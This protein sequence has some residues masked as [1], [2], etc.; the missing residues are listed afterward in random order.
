M[1]FGE[2]LLLHTKESRV[3][4][5]NMEKKNIAVQT[6]RYIFR[7]CDELDVRMHAVANAD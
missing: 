6:N 1:V 7:V 4:L 5:K 2:T 3:L